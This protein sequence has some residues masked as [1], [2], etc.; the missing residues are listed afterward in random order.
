MPLT[1][2]QKA[3]LAELTTEERAE[4]LEALG[5]K[6]SDTDLLKTVETLQERFTAVEKALKRKGTEE[7]RKPSG[8]GVTWFEKIFGGA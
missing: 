2:A 4:F 5:S 7:R 3:K 8:G 6:G 1:D